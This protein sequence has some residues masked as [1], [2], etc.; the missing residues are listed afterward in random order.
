MDETAGQY[1]RLRR[2]TVRMP[3]P[4][5]RFRKMSEQT[6]NDNQAAI[7]HIHSSPEPDAHGQ[8][9]LLLTESLLHGLI[10]RSVIT[11]ADAVEIVGVAEEV[12]EEIAFELGDS[13]P[14]KRRSLHIL[15]D[16]RKS[17]EGELPGG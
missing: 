5:R 2:L 3:L 4:G 7:A 1:L 6:S 14:T 17:I 13:T 16:I 15:A 12:K 10:A 8:A 9:A 11:V